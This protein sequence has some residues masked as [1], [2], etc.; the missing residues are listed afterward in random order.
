MMP[1]AKQF[2]RQFQHALHEELAE[3][4]FCK[5][6]IRGANGDGSMFFYVCHKRGAQ[7]CLSILAE[8]ILAADGRLRFLIVDGMHAI[9][10]P[11]MV[12]KRVFNT[13]D[14]P[15]VAFCKLVVRDM[16][17]AIDVAVTGETEASVLFDAR[18]VVAGPEVKAAKRVGEAP[19]APPSTA[20]ILT[21]G[22]AALLRPVVPKGPAQRDAQ[23]ETVLPCAAEEPAAAVPAPPPG[24]D[25]LAPADDSDVVAGAGASGSADPPG[26]PAMAAAHVERALGPR[27]RRGERSGAFGPWAIAPIFSNRAG[28]EPEQIGWGATCRQHSDP[29]D[30]PH[31]WCKKQLIFGKTMCPQEARCRIKQWLLAGRGI[32][33][34]SA[35]PRTEHLAINPRS[36]PLQDEADVDR[37]VG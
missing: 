16:K 27:A 6:N 14:D 2:I 36:L 32:G 7:P 15:V 35:Q 30:P 19:G 3:G 21:A 10:L 17:D 28:G 29:G 20:D 1:R 22:M 11:S 37:A 5:L 34:F 4:E 25:F 33:C 13:F 31:R 18:A 9:V 8:C 26:P 24:A 12:A 23:I